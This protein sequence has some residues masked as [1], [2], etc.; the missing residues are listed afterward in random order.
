MDDDLEE[1]V[2]EFYDNDEIDMDYEFD[3]ARFYDFTKP[4]TDW[5]DR[6]AELWFESSGNYSP[7]PFI[8]KLNWLNGVCDELGD[9][10]VDSEDGEDRNVDSP[11]ESKV[12][13]TSGDNR[14]LITY[15]QIPR[16]IS[17]G[18]TKFLVKSTLSK[19][20]T[21]MKPT[22]SHLAKQNQLQLSPQCLRRCQQKFG[23][24][25]G[26]TLPNSSV[27]NLATKR[28][29]LEAG[30]L[31][32]VSQLKHQA[33]LLHKVSKKVGADVNSVNARPRVTIPREPDLETAHR[34]ERHRCKIIAESGKQAKSNSCIFKARPLN[35]KILKAPSLPL[36]KRSKPQQPEFQV[37]NLKTSERA[38]QHALN[39]AKNIP[40]SGSILENETL[41][42]KRSNNANAW[43]QVK[44]KT[45]DIGKVGGPLLNKKTLSIEGE[46]CIFRSIEPETIV[47]RV[48]EFPTDKKVQDEPPIDSFSKLSL[49][50][51]TPNNGKP[52]LK[53]PLP[54]KGM[55]ENTPSSFNQELEMISIFKE[56]MQRFDGKDYKCGS[57]RRISGRQF[58]FYRSLD[59]R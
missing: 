43:K 34:A 9:T 24:I 29:K 37:F 27:D 58:F 7:S 59:M 55:D 13:S 6:E 35:R 38:M 12:S 39:S 42:D 5:E 30:Y 32:K 57:N 56:R 46:K 20:S 50:S 53:T 49:T 11:M 1:F 17:K 10:C 22:A 44:S 26:K 4:E 19:S 8:V 40:N 18:K 47:T 3:A 45:V 25:D 48:I 14:G 52:S 54:A 15:N 21:L 36:L 28:Q 51:E 33:M 23:N 2:R 31:C 41:E 16:Y